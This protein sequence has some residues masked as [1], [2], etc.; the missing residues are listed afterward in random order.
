MLEQ[1]GLCLN[2]RFDLLRRMCFTPPIISFLHVDRPLRSASSALSTSASAP[3]AGSRQRSFSTRL[4]LLLQKKTQ[5][6]CS[7]EARSQRDNGCY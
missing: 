4:Q 7:R 1:F 6:Q 2:S 5:L 3:C